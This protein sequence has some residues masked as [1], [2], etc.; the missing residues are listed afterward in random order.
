M[1][2][3]GFT[4]LSTITLTSVTPVYAQTNND[5]VKVTVV[6]NGLT[7]IQSLY[8]YNSEYD[9]ITADIDDTT[10]TKVIGTFDLT[11]ATIDSY[12]IC[13]EDS[14]GGIKCGLD[15]DI[16]TDEVGSI[17]VESNPSGA[18]VY[19]DSDY[20]GTTPLTIE[21]ASLGSHKITIS[22]TGYVDYIKWVTVK[23]D[24]TSSV[25]ADLDAVA[26]A[27]TTGAP[28]VATTKTPLK[29]TTVKV[30]TSWP[31]PATTQTSLD[32]TLVLGAIGLGVLVLYRK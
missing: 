26:T 2:S 16:V 15:F 4:I 27:V 24:S 3:D 30:P 20:A 18:K 28:T 9:N 10:A 5:S 14:Y 25:S 11:D 29:V 1:L 23:V 8:L 7:D 6:G 13:V 12:D 32:A 19:L 31:T 22:K 21:D 17:D